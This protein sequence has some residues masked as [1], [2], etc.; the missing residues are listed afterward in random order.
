MKVYHPTEEEFTNPITYI[1]Q[2]YAEGAS[3]YGCIKIVPPASFN[4]R[5]AFDMLSQ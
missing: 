4:P 1:E 5:L 3:K 2:L